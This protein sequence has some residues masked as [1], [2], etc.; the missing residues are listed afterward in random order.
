MF[1]EETQFMVFCIEDGS[2][3]CDNNMVVINNVKPG[4]AVWVEG[5]SNALNQEVVLP[6]AN[7]AVVSCSQT[8]D[9]ILPPCSSKWRLQGTL[10]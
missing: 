9:A 8:S 7:Q 3:Y 4:L 10:K 6:N 1:Y 2:A 5:G